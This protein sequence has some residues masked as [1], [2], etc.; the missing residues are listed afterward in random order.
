MGVVLGA[1]CVL[2][3]VHHD[4]VEH[5][6]QSAFVFTFF[7]LEALAELGVCPPVEVGRQGVVLPVHEAVGVAE[8]VPAVE[9]ARSTKG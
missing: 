1:A 9:E 3:E 6:A 7:G 8:V 5:V 2:G 4:L